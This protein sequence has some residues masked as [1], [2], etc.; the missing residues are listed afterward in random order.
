MVTTR[1][2][3]DPVHLPDGSL[4]TRFRQSHIFGSTTPGAGVTLETGTDGNFDDGSTTADNAGSFTLD[5]SLAEGMTM[6]QVRVRDSFGQVLT[7]ALSVTLD[8]VPPTEPVIDLD[9]AFDSPPVGDGRT[10]FDIVTLVGQTE[11]NAWVALQ[12]RSVVTTADALG[13]FAFLGV[14]LA[15]GDNAFTVRAMDAAGNASFFGKVIERV[16]ADMDAPVLV[17]EA[18]LADGQHSGTVRLIGTASDLGTGIETVRYAVDNGAFVTLTL[19][20]AGRFDQALAMPPLAVGMHQVLVQAFDAAGNLT[21]QTVA[22]DVSPDFVLGPAGSSGWGVKTATTVRLE[23]RD[24]FLVQTFLP[25]TLGQMMGTRKLQF[26][27]EANLDPRDGT[28][29]SP[30]L[31]L[32]YLVDPVTGQTLVDQGQPGT[33]LFALGGATAEFRPGLVRFD[34]TLVEIDVTGVT[35]T[36][37]GLLVFQ[38]LNGDSDTGSVVH[39]RSLANVPDAEGISGP[40]FPTSFSN[41]PAGAALNLENLT[42]SQEVQLLVSKVRF[43]PMTGRYTAD[44]QVRNDGPAVGRQVLAVFPGLPMGVQLLG[45]SGLDANANPYINFQEAIPAGGLGTNAL[46][47]PVQVVFN[48][49]SLLRFALTPTIL[50]GPG[51]RPPVFAPIGPLSVMPGGSLDV[52]LVATDPDGDRVLFSLRPEGAMPTSLLRGDGVL[53]I[54]PTPSEV[55]SYAFTLTA[56]DG[57]AATE[58]RVTLTVTADAVTTT[59][60][61]GVI[62]NTNG[63]PLAGVPVELG[64]FQTVTAADGSFTLELP[65]TAMLTSDFDIPI[66]SDDPQFDPFSTG[67]QTITF[68]RAI[69]DPTTGTDTNNPRRQINQV[70]AFLDASVVY[71]SD[72]ARAAAL[73]TND[74]TG[75]LKTSP[76]DLLPFN[77][78]TYFPGG[79]LPNDNESIFPAETMF[80][81]GDV[82]TSENVGLTALH[83]VFLR[84]HNRLADRYRAA[85]PGWTDEQIYQAARKMVGALLQQITYSE[86]IPALLG[87]NALPAYTGYNPA[88]DPSESAVF[89]TVAFRVGHTL[90]PPD[91]PRLA[92]DG[93]SLPGGPLSL[94]EAFFNT[95]PVVR[96]GIDPYLRG[97]AAQR[98]QEVD[99]QVIDELRNFLF[100]PPGSGGMDL[101]VLNMQRARDLGLP[102]YNTARADFGLPRVTSFAQITSDPALQAKLQS[103]YSSVDEIDPWV[104]GLC[105]DHLLGAAVGPFFAAVLKDQFLR[106]RDGD[107]FW[108]ENG[109]FNAAELA[110]IRGTTLAG[111]IER[112]TGITGL[113][114]NVFTHLAPPPAPDPAGGPGATAEVRSIDGSGNNL[115]N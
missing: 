51:N 22:F 13:R 24:S 91:V 32:V 81:A 14:A 94:R 74:G 76:G 97:A 93:N 26:E 110:E 73:R 84:E 9:P 71:G 68:R 64:R 80:V 55:G 83:T 23:E 109:Q 95:A 27:V 62:L 99:N 40:V 41:A 113:P 108:F 85:N 34:G 61:S 15:P 65:P 75:R 104:G 28:T 16:A 4:L 2:D 30:D 69:F 10:T 44:L 48:D 111:L 35:G 103:V 38:M 114:A 46:S 66:P 25:V 90:F 52:P 45:P 5:V 100:G 58:Q 21:Q 115:A 18:P 57:A 77:N 12:E 36:T 53:V 59:R 42:L 8:T 49:P 56:S 63:E 17:V 37:M 31:F 67:M 78:T 106:S 107:R 101:P 102:D 1:L 89:S 11:P 3:P 60:I 43:D 70:S 54:T 82:R 19:D 20:N 72:A 47:D 6:L 29:A 92:S 96:D 79:P 7:V 87:S 50:V 98:S 86:F 112:T 39:V 105:E 88:V 33:A